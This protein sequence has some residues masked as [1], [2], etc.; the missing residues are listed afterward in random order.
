M[1]ESGLIKYG[2]PEGMHDDCVSSVMLCA[3]GLSKNR[4]EVVG[5]MAME[6]VAEDYAISEYGSD[7]DRYID[8]DENEPV[9]KLRF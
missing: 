5:E 8:W 4:T 2:A 6:E 3:W 7:D 9:R 1:E